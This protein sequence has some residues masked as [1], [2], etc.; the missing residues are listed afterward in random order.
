MALYGLFNNIWVSGVELVADE[1]DEIILRLE[2]RHIKLD[3]MTQ[4]LW[5]MYPECEPKTRGPFTW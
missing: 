2:K 5:I 3:L 4:N 1:K